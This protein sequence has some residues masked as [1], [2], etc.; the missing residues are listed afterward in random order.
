MHLFYKSDKSKTV[1]LQTVSTCETKIFFQMKIRLNHIIITSVFAFSLFSCQKELTSDE[2]TGPGGGAKDLLKMKINGVQWVA[3]NGAGG[4]LL[5]GFINIYGLSKDKK[6]FSITLTDT[7][8]GVYV[9]DQNSL[10]AAAFADSTDP[11]PYAYTSNQGAD[12]TYAGGVVIISKI[13]KQKKTFSGNFQFKLYREIDNKQLMI[14]EGVFENLS[15]STILPPTNSTDTFLVKID[16]VVWKGKSISAGVVSGNLYITA[17]ELNLSKTVGLS[18]PPDIT[19]GVYDLD[20]GGMYIGSYFPS[21][22]KFWFSENGKLTIIEHNVSTKRL[23][24]NFYFKARDPQGGGG[25]AKLT[26]GY[27]SVKYN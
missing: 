19:P 18:M 15:Y 21:D 16:E 6:T 10:D 8:T 22:T 3:N 9:L 27:F 20:F 25:S 12:T 5:G 11:N 13:D 17:S 24:G 4:S 26:E 7:V 2:I 23:K 14:T 1:F